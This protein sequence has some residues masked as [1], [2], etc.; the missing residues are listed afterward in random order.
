MSLLER[1]PTAGLPVLA[2]WKIGP[3]S[4][5]IFEILNMGNHMRAVR[6]GIL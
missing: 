2:Y 4:I 5:G 3:S 6:I 1:F